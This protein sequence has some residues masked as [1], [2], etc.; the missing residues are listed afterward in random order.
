M[1]KLPSI[2]I[3]TISHEPTNKKDKPY[4]RTITEK[5]INPTTT[6]E[7]TSNTQKQ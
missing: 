2:N 6:N 7:K 3:I 1:N 4:K 5:S